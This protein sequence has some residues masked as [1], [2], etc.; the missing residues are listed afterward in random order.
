MKALIL[1]GCGFIGSHV[2]DALLAD[3]CLVRVFDQ[4]QECFRPARQGVDYIFGDFSNQT[5]MLEALTG[6]DTVFH[7]ISTTFPGT[8]NIDPQA[9]VTDNL[10]NT[11]KLLKAMI[12]LGIP[13]ILYLSSGGTVYGVPEITPIPE[14]HPLRP[15]NSYGIVKAAIEHYLEMYRREGK[16]SS[17]IIRP[18]NPYGPRQAHTGVQG[19]IATFMKRALDGRPIEIWGDGTVVRDYFHVEDLAKLCATAAASEAGGPFNAGS[20]TGT[21]LNDIIASI[22]VVTGVEVARVYKPARSVDVPNSVLDV[23]RAAAVFGWKPRIALQDGLEDCC[24]WFRAQRDRETG[25][26]ATAYSTPFPKVRAEA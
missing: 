11:L 7:L 2:V 6:I 23:T 9:D 8:A 3:N 22:A 18:A 26:P 17:I 25:I 12:D 4:H 19:V 1:G 10:I 14:D 21:S 15:I 16:L 13:R 5:L 20:G 24:A